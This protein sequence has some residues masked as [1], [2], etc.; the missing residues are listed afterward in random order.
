MLT[1]MSITLKR[2]AF[3]A[4]SLAISAG[5]AMADK[6]DGNW[7]SPTNATMT[8][9]GPSVTTPSG[10]VTRGDYY[11]HHFD[12]IVPDGDKEAGAR[13][14]ADLIDE[15]HIILTLTP[16][17]AAKPGQPEIWKRCQVVS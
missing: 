9:E 3:I 1:P 16:P 4:V 14:H 2:T 11:R 17:K 8:I 10:K 15:D 12:Y 5:A 6:I 13:V 7:C